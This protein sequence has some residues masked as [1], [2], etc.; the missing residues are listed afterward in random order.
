MN[1]VDLS[2][3]LVNWLWK[4][5][6]VYLLYVL[7]TGIIWPVI[8][9]TPEKIDV[10]P[11]FVETSEKVALLEYGIE[12]FGARMDIIDGAEDTIDVA[13]FYMKEGES[14]DLF[15]AYILA[16]ANRGVK[17][18]YI[19][20]GVFHGVRGEDRDVMHA[21]NEHPNIEFK[22]HE[23][24]SS[25]FYAPWRINN[26]LHD[27]LLLV[28]NKYSVS[29]GRNVSD[30]YYER[31]SS[32]MAY[33]FDRDIFMMKTEAD[34]AGVIDQMG[35]YYTE[36]FNSDYAVDQTNWSTFDWSGDKAEEKM[37]E[38]EGVYLDY[39]KEREDREPL[40]S[41]ETWEAKAVDIDQGYYVHNEL[42][43][44]F[45]QPFVWSHLLTLA[46]QAEEHLYVQSPW[47]V[48]NSQMRADIEATDFQASE[49]LMLTNGMSTGNNIGG[50]AGTENRKSVFIDSFMDYY[51]YQPKE[52]TLHTKTW[53]FDKQISAIG[54]FNLDARSSYLSTESMVILDS[55]ALA[56]QLLAEAEE[57]YLEKSAQVYPDDSES[58]G[59]KTKGQNPT[60]Q[61]RA[62][63]PILRS[64]AWL[65]EDLL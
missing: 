52:S 17:V 50:Q 13:Y 47:I 23:P 53:V 3:K 56:E 16:A 4:T 33:S 7:V 59:E 1:Q 61:M 62:M 63:M 26:R 37:A 48:P 51:E 57:S 30:L 42:S 46:S 19:L 12:A 27:K 60:W 21:F 6:A 31:T 39:K 24:I 65:L 44:G 28:D 38:L 35:D 8:S 55:E 58:N 18:R 54:S 10:Q 41:I 5:A 29:G 49:G 25:V 15:Y 40:T 20:D 9:P 64:F 43:R 36:L 34:E 2:R 14:V 22:L 32:D 45:K 11:G